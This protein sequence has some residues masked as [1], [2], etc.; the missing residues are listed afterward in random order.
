MKQPNEYVENRLKYDSDF[1]K[2][3]INHFTIIDLILGDKSVLTGFPPYADPFVNGRMI[4]QYKVR[5]NSNFNRLS[6]LKYFGIYVF[7]ANRFEYQMY[8]VTKTINKFTYKEE[9]EFKLFNFISYADDE[10][11]EIGL[12][13]TKDYRYGMNPMQGQGWYRNYSDYKVDFNGLYECSPFK[14]IKFGDYGFYWK[15][16]YLKRRMLRLCYKQGAFEFMKDIARNEVDWRVV[17]DNRIKKYRNII[18]RYD[19]S[20]QDFKLLLDL[21]KFK[22]PINHKAIKLLG[23]LTDM[24]VITKME[25]MNNELDWNKLQN[26]LVYQNKKLSYYRDYLNMLKQLKTKNMSSKK[27]YPENLRKAHDDLVLRFEKIKL[28][29]KLKK[30]KKIQAKYE[31]RLELISKYEYESEN[32]YFK[33]RVPMNLFEIVEEGTKLQHCVKNY[34]YVEGHSKGEFNI[35]F[36]RLKSDPNEPLYTF[37]LENDLRITQ[38]H[39]YRNK[40][41]ENVMHEVIRKFLFD[42][43]LPWVKAGCKQPQQKK[44]RMQPSNQMVM[45][46]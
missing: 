32:G 8:I 30:E 21:E 10:V 3:C 26:Y 15:D 33:V 43:Y 6:E 31:K 44:V 5:K 42:E 17:T 1:E 35:L 20:Y 37:T 13:S 36:V 39:G 18:A 46:G 7:D 16:A 22:F 25:C 19:Y 38:F 23:G 11:V 27:L 45:Q 9:F 24:E 2:W 34:S 4:K 40:D 29:E 41:R 28:N 12:E 14:G